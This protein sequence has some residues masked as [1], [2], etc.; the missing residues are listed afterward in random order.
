VRFRDKEISARRPCPDRTRSDC[1][2]ES[3]VR[4]AL[5]ALRAQAAQEK[6]YPL[7]ASG[8][9][10]ERV[11]RMCREEGVGYVDLAGNCAL[12]LKDCFVE[13]TVEKNPFPR[14]GRPAS[15]F[16]PRAARVLRLM[17]EEPRRTWSLQELSR[18]AAVSLG[19]AYNVSRRLLDEG[20]AQRADRRLV[21][22]RPGDLLDAW[23][24]AS[25]STP[26]AFE[27][28]AFYSFERDPG[29]LLRKVAAAG[30]KRG[31]RYAAT[32][33]GAAERLAPYV[34]GIGVLQW[35]V[36]DVAAVRSWVEALD[37]RPAEAGA[38]VILRVPKD[39]GV[40]I[41]SSEADGISV[42]GKIQLYLDLLQ[43]PGRGREQ[44]EFL[45]EKKIGF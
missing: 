29:Q 26:P 44:A 45:R 1:E 11:R 35:Y 15:L 3:K 7:L 31:W 33:F 37:L 12:Q 43:E 40:W 22:Q 14:R 23:R 38:N 25:A 41:G 20:F 9:L 32:S 17:L 34:H 2:G 30:R 36:E 24:D 19:Q 16:S 39:A 5:K 10:S 4:E 21:L 27:A 42:V 13:R 18:T 8:F 28:A 6:G